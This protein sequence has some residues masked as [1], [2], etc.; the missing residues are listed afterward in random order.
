MNECPKKIVLEVVKNL[1]NP[2]QAARCVQVGLKMGLKPI[3]QVYRL[4][5]SKNSANRSGTKKQVRFSRQEID[6]LEIQILDGK[7]MFVDDDGKPLYKA[8][9]MVNADNDSEVEEVETKLDDDYDPYDDD[10]YDGYDMSDNLQAHC[11][12]LDI[13]V[14]GRKKK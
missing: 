8:D 12:D 10:L 3:K 2:R 4:V 7:L 6:K 11:D 5:S 1:K 13:K 9:C 14:R